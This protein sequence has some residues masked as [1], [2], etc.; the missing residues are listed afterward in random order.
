MKA[1]FLERR[2]F[3]VSITLLAFALRVWQLDNTPPG[4]SDD[5][6]SNVFVLAQKIFEGDWSLYYTDATGLEAPYHIVSGILLRLFGFNVVG[7]RLLSAFLGTLSVPVTYQMGRTLFNR[8]LGLIAAA[9]LAVSFW[10]LMYSRVNLRHVALPMAAVG[11]FYWFWRGLKMEIGDWRLEINTGPISN[12]QCLVSSLRSPFLIAGLLLGLSFYTYFASR[13]IPLILAAFVLYLALFGRRRLRERWRAVLAMFLLAG[14][15]ASPLVATVLREA[16]ADARVTEVAVPLVEAR[17]GNFEPLLRHVR[18]TLSMFHADGDDEFLYNIPHRPV[19][20]APGALFLWAGVLISAGWAARPLWRA[21]V[22]RRI[23]GG[24]TSGVRLRREEAA[25]ALLLLWWAAGITP[26]FL[27][28]PPASLGHTILAQPATYL[29]MAVPLAPLARLLQRT[30]APQGLVIGAVGLLLVAGVAWRDLPDY[31]GTWPQRGMVRFLYHADAEDVAEFVA[32]R[33]GPADFAISGQLAGPWDRLALQIAL[34]NAG[35]QEAQPRWYHGQRAMFLSLSGEGAMAFR[36]YP[37]EEQAY[38]VF[39]ASLGVSA[40][41]YELAAVRAELPSCREHACFENGL[42]LMGMS[43][44]PGRDT[45][46]RLH[47]TWLVREPLQLPEIPVY[48]KPPPPGVYD[49]P[50][51]QVFAQHWSNDGEFID[52]DDGLWVDPL[53][54]QSGDVFRQQHRFPASTELSGYLVIGLYDPMTGQRILTEEGTDHIQLDLNLMGGRQS[55]WR[56]RR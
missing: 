48:S 52:G 12:H 49:G 47:V 26:G 50:R 22:Q 10:S 21:V 55:S 24:A 54:L 53:T 25:G 20:G 9:A 29:L 14:V 3:P 7:I 2:L 51:L 8:R 56:P 40:G 28:V 36:G 42:C 17:A 18:V 38:E 39:Y 41:D 11:V 15:I 34:E 19:F 13:G 30:R 43:Y 33:D 46:D 6:L 1:G 45:W 35:V 31:F 44:E 16:G 23:N 5:E 4:W 37:E 27:S 32:R